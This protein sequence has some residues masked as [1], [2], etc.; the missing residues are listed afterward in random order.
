[1]NNGD[2]SDDCSDGDVNIG[3]ENDC[4]SDR[5]DGDQGDDNWN[6]GSG[7]DGGGREAAG[8]DAS[9]GSMHAKGGTLPLIQDPSRPWPKRSRIPTFAMI[10]K[11]PETEQHAQNC[12]VKHTANLLKGKAL[13]NNMPHDALRSQA[14]RQARR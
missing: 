4:D 9:L 11:E 5:W 7:G 6:S 1:M 13:L 12:F 14:V 3:E 10:G 8:E 2:D